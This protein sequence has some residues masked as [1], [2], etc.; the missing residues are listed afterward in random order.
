MPSTLQSCSGRASKI[1]LR[2]PKASRS[3]SASPKGSAE[4]RARPR[5][6]ERL[7][8][9]VM[10]SKEPSETASSRSRRFSRF[11]TFLRSAARVVSASRTKV[12]CS[13][14]T[15]ARLV[16]VFMVSPCRACG[17]A[18]VP[19]VAPYLYMIIHL[20]CYSVKRSALHPAVNR[21]FF[22]EDKKKSGPC[23]G[24]DLRRP[25]AAFVIRAAVF[26]S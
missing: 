18:T 6:T 20:S 26:S 16:S 7:S 13:K 22:P 25:G 21:L 9:S 11:C 14:F 10:Q 4:P 1:A 12:S 24:P 15:V 5:M 17:P 23:R 8:D 19:E 2:L 3:L